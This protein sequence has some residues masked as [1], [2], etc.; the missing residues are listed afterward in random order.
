[1][2][3]WSNPTASVARSTYA[4]MRAPGMQLASLPLEGSRRKCCVWISLA[5]RWALR[6]VVP[7]LA[8]ALTARTAMR[9]AMTA[10]LT[11]CIGGSLGGGERRRGEPSPAPLTVPLRSRYRGAVTRVAPHVLNQ[12]PRGVARRE[13]HVGAEPPGAVGRQLLAV[14]AHRHARDEVA[15]R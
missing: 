10:W 2:R 6:F 15:R 8:T 13:L 1:M 5:A 7:A 3:I 14:L 12:D 4:S 11:R 9:A